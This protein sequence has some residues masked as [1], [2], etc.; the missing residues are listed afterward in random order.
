[1]PNNRSRTESLETIGGAP[2]RA[3]RVAG[4]IPRQDPA[5]AAALAVH[6]L[7]K[8]ISELP[9]DAL[10]GLVVSARGI[11]GWVNEAAPADYLEDLAYAFDPIAKIKAA[12]HRPSLS[13]PLLEVVAVHQRGHGDELHDVDGRHTQPPSGQEMNAVPMSALDP[14]WDFLS[15][16]NTVPG[17]M[18]SILMSPASDI[19]Q[20]MS[21]A[22]WRSTFAAR[23]GASWQ[24]YRGTPI[25]LRVILHADNEQIPARMRAELRVLTQQLTF[26]SLSRADERE[27]AEP[28]VV[29]V[30]GHTVPEGVF[31]S[32]VRLPGAVEGVPVPGLR[33]IRPP[34]AQIP[35]NRPPKPEVA[36]QLGRCVSAGGSARPVWVSPDDLCR[37]MRIVG[38]TG[39][40]KSTALR[41]LLGQLVEQ[42][43]GV[44]LLD[45]HG[46]LAADL[47]RDIHD[48]ERVL[49]IDYSDPESAPPFN[50]LRGKTQ[51]EFDARLQAFVSIIVDRDSEEYTG[52]KWRRTFGLVGRACWKLLHER[53]SLVAAFS[54][55]GSQELSN[56]LAAALQLVDCSLQ[57]QLHQELGN[58]RGETNSDLWSWLV[59]KGEEILGSEGLTRILGSGAHAV[60]L[61]EAISESRAV[62]INLGL[63]GLG[64]RSAQLL[65]CMWIAE[66]RQAMLNRKPGD[67]PFVLAIDEAHLFQ[68]GALPSL[69]DQARKFGIGVIVCHQRPDQLR[70][71]LKDALAANAGSYL[72]LR[73]GNPQDAAIAS[74]ML[75]NWPI[76]DLTRMPDLTGAAIVS[77]DGVPSEPFSFR[78]DFF[79]RHAQQLAD[80]E[81][82]ERRAS[83]VREASVNQLVAPYRSLKPSTRAGISKQLAQARN[84]QRDRELA[85]LESLAPASSDMS[86]RSTSVPSWLS[87]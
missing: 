78:F 49:H 67:R 77:R 3:F 79:T 75:S 12:S 69:L 24:L 28:E 22:I 53:A 52:P 59:C 25:R 34:K 61:D 14:M 20:E 81:S 39:S 45:P 50:P 8:L 15:V 82:R 27:L 73:T 83:T 60:N 6:N 23:M 48:P 84:E 17:G 44:M 35:Y 71:Q 55:L 51:A 47:A 18:M 29:A 76:T 42:G 62:L 68:Y 40:G 36:V 2:V 58:I 63:A 64:E 85:R 5:K 19:E 1:M 56:E 9:T 87:E 16:L 33:T 21:D 31:R 74:T 26:R 38:S 10:I 41:G 72:Q 86:D 7:V 11:A 57:A 13:R 4:L 70:F 80:L 32:L 37:H 30:K 46:T 54:I 66:L 65:G 43:Y